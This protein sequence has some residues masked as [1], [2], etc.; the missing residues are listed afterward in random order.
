MRNQKSLFTVCFYAVDAQSKTVIERTV[1]RWTE[2]KDKE[3]FYILTAAE[4][5]DIMKRA[6]ERFRVNFFGS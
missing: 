2:I 3:F 1:A 5:R 6:V 4:G